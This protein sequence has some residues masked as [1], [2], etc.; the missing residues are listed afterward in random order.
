MLLRFSPEEVTQVI[1]YGRPGTP[2][3]AWGIAGGGALPEQPVHDLVNYLK[4]IQI[5][6]EEAKKRSTERLEG[7][8][9]EE[10]GVSE[11]EAL[12][13]INCARCHTKGFSYGDPQLAAGGGASGRTCRTASTLRQFPA[14]SGGVRRST[15]TS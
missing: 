9:G 5:T 3:P 8:P 11:G 6:P 12:F 15:S 1:V 14:L 7:V 2:M 13:N 10:P 4:S